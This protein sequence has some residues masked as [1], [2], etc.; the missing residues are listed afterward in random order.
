MN[1]PNVGNMYLDPPVILV[2]IDDCGELSKVSTT[3]F[4]N[5]GS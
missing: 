4:Q 5:W 1:I 3:R 2:I